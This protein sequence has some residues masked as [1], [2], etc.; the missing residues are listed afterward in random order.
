MKKHILLTPAPANTTLTVKLAQIVPDIC[1]RE[2]DFE[3]II[4]SVKNKLLNVVDGD[5]KYS[6]ILFTASGTGAMEA[7]LSSLPEENNLILENGAYGKRMKEITKNYNK[8]M[9]DYK[10]SWGSSFNYKNIDFTKAK[11]VSVVHHETTTG[12]LNDINYIGNICKKHNILYVV[13][14]ISS[15][16]ALP[17]S[18]RKSNIDFLIGSS[19]KC[20][21]GLPGVSFVIVKKE[22]LEKTK[23]D[24]NYYFNLYRNYKYQ[25]NFRQTLFTPAVQCIYAFNQALD[26]YFK[27]GRIN[28]YKRYSKNWSLLISGMK[29]LGFKK[30]LKNSEE[31]RLV[32]TFEEPKG[33]C[34][35][36]FYKYLYRRG[37]TIYPGKLLNKKTFR[38]GN[39]GDINC[40]D[41]NKFINTV[42]SY[43]R[44]L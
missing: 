1:P 17:I 40:N 10:I 11:I 16:G 23:K 39:I 25:E 12:I 13:D 21:Q 29:K 8:P 37:F 22:S 44:S 28:R 7:V 20:L 6:V 43:L 5:N 2:K 15:I 38:I 4:N 9:I 27:E 41:V 34:F 24:G 3:K 19:N 18:I 30:I 14:A 42:A 26:E 36:S 32:T 35:S 33:F 31:S